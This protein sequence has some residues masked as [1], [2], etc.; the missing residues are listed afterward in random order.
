[1]AYILDPIAL[2]NRT[3]AESHGFIKTF[4]GYFSRVLDSFGIADGDAA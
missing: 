2:P 3:E 1:L 4:G